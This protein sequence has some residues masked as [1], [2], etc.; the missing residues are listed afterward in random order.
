MFEQNM[1]RVINVSN[2]L[3]TSCFIN[4]CYESYQLVKHNCLR[5]RM[6]CAEAPP[7][8]PLQDRGREGE[9]IGEGKG[10]GKEGIYVCAILRNSH[11]ELFAHF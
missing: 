2:C 1:L 10:Q 6:V 7:S 4:I 3:K 11:F 8:L 5:N 9:V